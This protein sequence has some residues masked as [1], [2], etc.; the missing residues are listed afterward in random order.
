MNPILKQIKEET[1]KFQKQMEE[2]V[3]HAFEKY[4]E[5]QPAAFLLT[6]IEGKFQA[7]VIELNEVMRD[8]RGKDLAHEIIKQACQ[9][10]KPFAMAF[11]S[12]GWMVSGDKKDVSELLDEQGNMKVRPMDHPDRI[13]TVFINFETLDKVGMQ[14]WKIIREEGKEP[15]LEPHV[16][17][18]EE[19]WQNK[20]DL[21]IEGRFSGFLNDML[22]DMFKDAPNNTEIKDTNVK[23]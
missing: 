10:L 13:E 6:F 23:N 2:E 22:M 15:R 14:S 12:E 9:Q 7:G 18:T 3:L 21:K 4:K 5:V 16:I 17:L 8:D 11:V 19:H 20:K 1:E